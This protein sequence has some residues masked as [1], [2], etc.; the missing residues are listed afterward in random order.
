MLVDVHLQMLQQDSLTFNFRVSS[1]P[2][3]RSVLL[4]DSKPMRATMEW[5]CLNVTLT[6]GQHSRG[7]NFA[8]SWP[9]KDKQIDSQHLEAITK[10]DKQNV[11][12][13]QSWEWP[14]P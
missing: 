2:Q 10:M 4:N 12:F 13:K 1:Q 9:I 3:K 5:W 6:A 8:N 14:E 7:R 11:E